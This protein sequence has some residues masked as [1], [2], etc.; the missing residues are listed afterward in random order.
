VGAK[1]IT[2]MLIA[3]EDVRRAETLL[4]AKL[5]NPSSPAKAIRELVENDGVDRYVARRV[6]SDMVYMKQLRYVTPNRVVFER[7]VQ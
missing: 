1:E 4:K 2:A 3:R 5:S 6:F 7:R